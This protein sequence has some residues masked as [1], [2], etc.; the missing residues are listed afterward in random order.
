MKELCA[1]TLWA[2]KLQKSRIGSPQIKV[3]CQQ[4]FTK[5]KALLENTVVSSD[6]ILDTYISTHTIKCF[7]QTVKDKCFVV[8]LTS[9][10]DNNNGLCRADHASDGSY[11]RALD[12]SI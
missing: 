5:W 12:V 4:E 3:V 11:F 1:S 7:Y 9:E 8:D 10:T 6:S 2:T